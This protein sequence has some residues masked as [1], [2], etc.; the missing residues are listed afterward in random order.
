[1][2]QRDL[3][4]ETIRDQNPARISQTHSSPTDLTECWQHAQNLALS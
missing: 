3:G 4:T 1:M 2:P